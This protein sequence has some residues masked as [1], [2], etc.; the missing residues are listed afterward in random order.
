MKPDQKLFLMD[1]EGAGFRAGVLSGRWGLAD[2]D[3]LPADMA[4]PRASFWLLAAERPGAPDRYYVMLDLSGYRAVSPTG[5][6]W[7][8]VGK[9]MLPA[10]GF[11]RGKT[12]SRF[13]QVFRTNWPP[14]LS[15]AFYHPYDRFTLS[16]HSD[17]TTTMRHLA[18][19]E[20]NT[21][22]DYLDEFQSL[23]MGDDYVGR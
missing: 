15:K 21:I 13:A 16:S 6:F 23:L 14:G 7:D 18:W 1:L 11:P 22:T 3:T 2:A 9:T 19:T 4:W 5:S 12:G 8:P 20:R 10:G 17:W